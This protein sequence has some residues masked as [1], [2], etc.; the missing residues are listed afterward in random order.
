MGY[1]VLKTSTAILFFASVFFSFPG[2]ARAVDD[3]LTEKFDYRGDA[4]FQGFY[5]ARDLPL[6]RTADPVCP[7][8][9]SAQAGIRSRCRE[10][11][12]FY[13]LRLR[14]RFSFRPSDYVDI[15]YHMEVGFLTFGRDTNNGHVTQTAGPNTGGRGGDRANLETQEL[16][17]KFKNK[18]DTLSLSLGLFGFGTPSGIV[19]ATSGAGAWFKKDLSDWNSRF[20]GVYIRSIDN[21]RIDDDSNGYSDDNF[22][23]IHLGVINW[24]FSGIPRLHSELYGVYRRD[25]DPSAGDPTDDDRETSRIYWAGLYLKYTS[26]R[27]SFLLHGIINRGSFHR[28]FA[29]DAPEVYWLSTLSPLDIFYQQYQDSVTFFGQPEQRKKYPVD[30]R[31]GEAKISYQATDTLEISTAAAAGSGRLDDDAYGRPPDLKPDYFRTAGSSGYQFSDIAV[32]SSGGYTLI[33]GGR[34]TGIYERGLIVKTQLL[35]TVEGEIG[36]FCVK[37]IHTPTID[38]NVHYRRYLNAE[39][40]DTYFGDEWNF[41]LTWRIFSDLTFQARAGIFN[42][43]VAYKVLH[44]AEY[45]DRILE[46]AFSVEQK[47]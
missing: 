39:R 27:W 1:R 12:D 41:K 8:P 30:A 25:D 21:S 26:G 40:S 23:D 16:I 3:S 36:Y 31:A 2:I 45:G 11:E 42:A 18:V 28:P 17:L 29:I 44:D 7:G 14:V 5:L 38:D 24:K 33:S 47:F 34:L 9:E 19:L 37:L 32:D 10:E 22:S 46:T 4:F 43:G 13:R 35:S 20:E 6:D 15:L